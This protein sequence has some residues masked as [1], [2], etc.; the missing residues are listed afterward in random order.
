MGRNWRGRGYRYEESECSGVYWGKDGREEMGLGL[1]VGSHW[2]HLQ[3]PDKRELKESGHTLRAEMIKTQGLQLG[4]EKR[5][6]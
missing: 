4:L 6:F 1:K 2:G 5:D 3:S